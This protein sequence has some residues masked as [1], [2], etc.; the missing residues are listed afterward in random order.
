VPLNM[1]GGVKFNT[2]LQ[3]SSSQPK[4]NF[5]AINKKAVVKKAGPMSSFPVGGKENT[6]LFN[7]TA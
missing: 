7:N 6:Q 5:L 2:T 3:Y 4:K 1:N